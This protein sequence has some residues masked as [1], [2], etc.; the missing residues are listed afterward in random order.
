MARTPVPGVDAHAC[1]PAPAPVRGV[2][3]DLDGTLLDTYALILESFRHA[4]RSVLGAALPD[5]VLMA[6]VGVPLAEEV[7]D[8]SDDPARQDELVRV[9]RAYNERV[10][11]ERVRA[12]PGVA[13]LLD[14]LAARG[15]RVGVVTSKRRALAER[16]LEVCG[17][18]DGVAFTLGSDDCARHKPDPDPVLAGCARLGLPPSACVYVGDAPFDVQAGKAAGCA[19]VAVTWGMFDEGTLR[20]ERPDFV[21]HAPGEV[22]GFLQAR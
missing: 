5:D 19:T 9:Y 11:D 8:F 15:V 14:L 10:H 2:L 22:A 12:F 3:F 21:A 13:D 17:L 1:I 7:K 6:R 20:A 4:T 18:A 16:G